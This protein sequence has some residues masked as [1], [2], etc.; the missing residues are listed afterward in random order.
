MVVSLQLA[1]STN[2]LSCGCKFLDYVY[3]VGDLWYNLFQKLID[4][5]ASPLRRRQCTS[6]TNIPWND[7]LFV[8]TKMRYH[9]NPFRKLTKCNEISPCWYTIVYD[10]NRSCL[11]RGSG[12]EI[13]RHSCPS[14]LSVELHP[15][16]S[17]TLNKT[18]S[19]RQPFKIIFSS[20]VLHKSW[21]KITTWDKQGI[22]P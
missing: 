11:E 18:A 8:S 3:I 9:A 14:S 15:H 7:V 17:K 22:Y 2:Q 12:T 10:I 6:N 5:P 16:S 19:N 20:T 13:G 1:S 21:Y 4:V